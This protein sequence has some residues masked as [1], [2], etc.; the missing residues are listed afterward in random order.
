MAAR[1]LAMLDKTQSAMEALHSLLYTVYDERVAAGGAATLSDDAF[2]AAGNYADMVAG[3]DF[4][5]ADLA[6]PPRLA[7]VTDRSESRCGQ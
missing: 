6:P 1:L 3:V 7:C 4:R 5:D 2:S